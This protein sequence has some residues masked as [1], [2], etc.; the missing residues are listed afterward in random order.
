MVWV[1]SESRTSTR[2]NRN[3]KDLNEGWSGPVPTLRFSFYKTTKT[4][5]MSWFFH[6][7]I[8]VFTLIKYKICLCLHQLGSRFRSR[9]RL[10]GVFSLRVKMTE[11]TNLA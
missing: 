8:N 3:L 7:E 4:V 5:N 6:Q 9:S 11:Q 1:L 2:L 10:S